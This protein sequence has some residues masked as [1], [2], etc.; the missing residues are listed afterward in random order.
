M[1]LTINT[2]SIGFFGLLF[3]YGAYQYWRLPNDVKY[4]PTIPQLLVPQQV[5][6]SRSIQSKTG[7]ASM[8]TEKNR[9]RAIQGVGRL[10]PSKIRES[11][12]TSGASTGAMETFMLTSICPPV[13]KT[14]IQQVVDAVE[15]FAAYIFD[16]G[17]ADDEYDLVLDGDQG[18]ESLDAGNANTQL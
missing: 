18:G 14:V 3:M 1:E 17:F 11:R 9:R 2:V 7:D 15:E 6:K 13:V 5:G 4:G 10:H 16:A 12:T 8:A